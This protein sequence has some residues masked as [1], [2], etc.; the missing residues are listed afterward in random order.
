[1][2]QCLICQEDFELNY[3][4]L[5]CNHTY[6]IE[7]F[8]AWFQVNKHTCCYCF[9]NFETFKEVK[10][11]RFD[12]LYNKPDL[13]DIIQK[14]QTITREL[15]KVIKENK[16][17]KQEFDEALVVLEESAAIIAKV[18]MEQR[19]KQISKKRKIREYEDL[20]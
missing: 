10:K 11:S 6:C 16:Q 4:K 17:L 5:D 2:E 14:K 3:I 15:Q 18:S 12:D 8:K 7:C 9:K 20:I 13:N 1:M 19:G